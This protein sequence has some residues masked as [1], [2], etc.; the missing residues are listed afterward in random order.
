M[1][2]TALRRQLV[3]LHEDGDFETVAQL[4]PQFRQERLSTRT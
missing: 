4:V 2:A 1:V 3:V